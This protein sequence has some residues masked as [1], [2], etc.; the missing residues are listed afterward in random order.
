MNKIV[1][2]VCATILLLCNIVWAETLQNVTVSWD[3]EPITDL[4]GFEIRLNEDNATLITVPAKVRTWSG[5]LSLQ[6]GNNTMDVQCIDTAGQRS[7]WSDPSGPIN[8]LPPK[9]WIKWLM[10]ERP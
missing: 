2:L 10:F 5:L 7:G 1:Y 9:A 6:D 4:A 3:M 8:P